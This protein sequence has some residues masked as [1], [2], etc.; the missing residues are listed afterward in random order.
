MLLLIDQVVT[1]L[2]SSWRKSQTEEKELI[3]A[4]A[5]DVVSSA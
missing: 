3:E 5:L 4:E 1:R 2:M